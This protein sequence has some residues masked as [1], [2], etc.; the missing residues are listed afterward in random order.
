M[1]IIDNFFCKNYFPPHDQRYYYKKKQ[2]IGKEYRSDI[3]NGQT[4]IDIAQ[5]Y[6]KMRSLAT[7]LFAYNMVDGKFI[8]DDS[9]AANH[10]ILNYANGQD[11]FSQVKAK[12]EDIDYSSISCEVE[13]CYLPTHIQFYNEND[14]LT[15]FVANIGEQCEICATRWSIGHK[16]VPRTN[17]RT[18]SDTIG[19][20][21][22]ITNPIIIKKIENTITALSYQIDDLIIKYTEVADERERAAK[23]KIKQNKAEFDEIK[24]VLGEA[25]FLIGVSSSTYKD[26]CCQAL[27]E[28]DYYFYELLHILSE[29]NH[30]AYIDWKEEFEDVKWSL[31]LVAEKQALPTI[32]DTIEKPSDDL[33]CEEIVKYIKSKNDIYTYFI[34]DVESDGC[35]VGIIKKEHQDKFILLME[36]IF[37][38]LKKEDYNTK[39]EKI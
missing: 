7:S 1:S 30:L 2:L 10:P 12:I 20:Y 34:I 4:I 39:I 24:D 37:S 15:Y 31:N 28:A 25:L 32:P 33:F 8:S 22:P 5:R 17:K 19:K 9:V 6:E 21:K 14:L 26:I 11:C 3:I 36:N 16:T 38:I 27:K 13:Y 35:M 29:E 23:E 18:W